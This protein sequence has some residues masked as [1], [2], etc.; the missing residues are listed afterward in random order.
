MSGLKRELLTFSFLVFLATQTPRKPQKRFW[1][2]YRKKNAC[3]NLGN[4]PGQGANLEGCQ[5]VVMAES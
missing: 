2:F 5:K 3:E 4:G 1:A